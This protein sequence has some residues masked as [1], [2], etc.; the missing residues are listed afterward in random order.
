[1]YYIVSLLIKEMCE[2]FRKIDIGC[3]GVVGIA[4]SF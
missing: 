1:M 2:I 4:P 3:D